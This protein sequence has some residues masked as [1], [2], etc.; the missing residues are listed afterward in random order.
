M[1]PREIIEPRNKIKKL[2]H[3]AVNQFRNK[4][5]MMKKNRYTTNVNWGPCVTR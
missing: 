4:G 1:I 5:E 2:E 3:D